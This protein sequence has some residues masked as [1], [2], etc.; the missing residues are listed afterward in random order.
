ME[1]VVMEIMKYNRLS[2]AIAA[3]M[4]AA[5]STPQAEVVEGTS[6]VELDGCSVTWISDTPE[7]RNNSLEL[8]PTASQELV[9][10][11]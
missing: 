7:P 3:A 1:L 10:F 6:T 9:D 8:F 4:M 2:A 11:R 5:C